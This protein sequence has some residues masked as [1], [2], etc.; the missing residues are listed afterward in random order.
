M[1]LRVNNSI[2]RLS[3]LTVAFNKKIELL[4]GMTD[5]HNHLDKLNKLMDPN[6]T[7][8]ATHIFTCIQVNDNFINIFDTVKATCKSNLKKNKNKNKIHI[9]TVE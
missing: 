3:I 9:L 6:S 5:P 2:N 4:M 7:H 1:I 8:Y